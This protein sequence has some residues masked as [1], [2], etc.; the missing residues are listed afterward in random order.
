MNLPNQ[1]T[2]ARIVLAFVFV[3]F[4]LIDAPWAKAFSLV[5]FLAAALTDLYD[6]YL[7]RRTGVVT[8]FGKFMDPLADKVLVSSALISFV[9]LGYIKAWMVVVIIF[10]EFM[11]TGLRLLAAYKGIVIVPSLWAQVKTFLEM[12]TIAAILI[13]TNLKAWLVPNG[14]DWAIFYSPWTLKSFN[15]LIFLAMLLSVGTGIDYL[16][17][18]APLLRGVL[19]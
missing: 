6:G 19:K 3:G 5:I 8:G 14:H 1:L 15:G 9:A 10:R 13:F 2:L 4:F 11:V 17:K 12:T 16:I 18:N 7:A